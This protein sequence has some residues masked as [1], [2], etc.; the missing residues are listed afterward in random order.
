MLY[1]RPLGLLWGKDADEAVE[2]QEA[3]RLAGGL[4]AFTLI[5]VISRGGPTIKRET[6]GLRA[7]AESRDDNLQNLL[8][9]IT[10]PR[11]PVA[12]LDLSRPSIMGIINVTPD[13]F[14]DGGEVFETAEAVAQG[15]RFAEEGAS[16]IDVGGESTRPGSEGIAEAVERERIVP[17]V[18]ALAAAG[19]RVSIDTR[20]ASIMRDAVKAGA[21]MINDVSALR[22][23]GMSLKTAAALGRP[24]C[25]MH[26]RG[27]PKT[28][29][30]NP[31]YE[32][33]ALDVFDELEG[34]IARAEAAGVKRSLILAD[35]GIGF[36]KSF[37][38]NLDLLKRLSL[39]HG[40]GVPI[41]MGASRKGFIG[42]LTGESAG[43][44]RAAGSIGIA[45]A[46]AAQ[47]AQL[48]RV[49]DVKATAQALK[50]WRASCEPETSGL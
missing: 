3:C 32:D 23:D 37:R 20:K 11:E 25:L 39:L 12:G 42:A 34:L 26:A 17:V 6:H 38:H 40:L 15:A 35:P 31:S 16:V 48:L 2:A 46:A 41:V 18:R 19:H 33:V 9:R 1:L 49:H 4:C 10:V 36:G 7:I 44:K 8:S 24:V 30:E 50:L 28:M 27:D 45:L 22:F 29:Q 14:S 21:Q 13:S 47:G 5:E 43:R